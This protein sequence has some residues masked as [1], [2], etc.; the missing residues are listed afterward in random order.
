MLEDMAKVGDE[1]I[2]SWQPHGKAFR[3]HQPEAF[4]R[5][6]MSR[7]FKQ[8]KYKSFQRQLHLYG[9]H[10][11]HGGMDRG[12]Y[13]HRMSIRNKKCMSLQMSYQRI[14]GKKLGKAVHHYAAGDPDFYSSA[15]NVD[16]SRYQ[17]GRSVTN[18]LPSD[19]TILQTYTTAGVKERDCT[20]HGP[21]GLFTTG[22]AGS[23][24]DHQHPGKVKP[25]LIN[26]AF[27]FN[28]DV[29]AGGLSPSR[30]LSGSERCPLLDWLEGGQ[31]H[32]VVSRDEEHASL[33]KGYDTLVFQMGHEAS[34]LLRGMNFENHG[35]DEGFFAGKRFHFVVETKT[36][37]TE[38]AFSAD[39]NRRAPMVYVSRSA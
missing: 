23:S 34:A 19:P 13:Y 26:S 15:T 31:A 1:S 16:K 27:P 11:M 25:L 32:P 29:V 10:R 17:D 3:V 2:V 24:I 28:Q 39:I 9:F 38:E 21:S 5:T 18:T 33:Y 8:T 6:V 4:T 12:A 7:Y 30:Q 22:T 14:K 36:P 37:P 20:K 35:A